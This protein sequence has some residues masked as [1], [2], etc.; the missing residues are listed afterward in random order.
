MGFGRVVASAML[1]IFAISSLEKILGT[2]ELAGRL[3]F[4]IMYESIPMWHR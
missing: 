3:G 2:K 1:K 4:G